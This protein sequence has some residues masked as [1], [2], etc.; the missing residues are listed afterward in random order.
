M[1]FSSMLFLFVFL[2]ALLV[3]YF[4][5]PK[6][7][8]W[9]RNT[10]LLVFSLIFY[11]SNEPVNILIM[12]ASIMLNW[13]LGLILERISAKKSVVFLS[14][15]LNLSVLIYF[16]YTNFICDNI[17]SLLGADLGVEKIIMPVG[18]SFFTFQAMSYVF[19]IY[20]GNTR[21]QK[22]PLNVILY[23]SLFP[24]LVAGPIVRYETIADEISNRSENEREI[25]EGISNFIIGF[26]K[27]MIIAN[28]VGSIAD[29]AF[30]E[31]NL[32]FAFAWLGIISYTLQIY[33]DFSAYSDMAIGLGKI[34]GFHFPQNFNYPYI[35]QSVT[36]FWRRW[37]ISLSVWF[38][39]YLYI[40]LGGNRCSKPKHLRNIMLVWLATGIWHGASWNFVVW[41][42][43]YGVLLIIEKE[44]LSVLLVKMPSALRH[45]YTMLIVLIGFVFFRADTLTDAWVYLKAMFTFKPFVLGAS[46]ELQL[47]FN[48]WLLLLIAVIGSM[49][50]V[51]LTDKIRLKAPLKFI[52]CMSMFLLSVMCLTSSTF[53]PFIYFRF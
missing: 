2:P 27:K 37:H 50:V 23:I 40:P 47:L 33:F 17:G 8:R 41:G 48:N 30:A 43:Y 5:V 45:I 42:L 34:F 18:I 21:A 49:P 28:G 32:N 20:F 31:H 53:N 44:F 9:L 36:E 15:L 51:R 3:V 1:V 14:V 46:N 52:C 10:V 12:L 24:Q 6:K 38:R 11:A 13:A 26:A 22:N 16:K 7:L 25:A 39:D 4:A 19:D 29:A 35:S